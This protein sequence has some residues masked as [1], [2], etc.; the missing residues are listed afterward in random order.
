MWFIHRLSCYDVL[1]S[2]WILT[3]SSCLLH[4][5]I[6]R[7]DL[8]ANHFHVTHFICFYHFASQWWYIEVWANALYSS[9]AAWIRGISSRRSTSTTS[10]RTSW[11][12]SRDSS[13]EATTTI[14]T[15]P[16][17]LRTPAICDETVSPRGSTEKWRPADCFYQYVTV[18]SCCCKIWNKPN[19]CKICKKHSS[20]F[21]N[22]FVLF[23]WWFMKF[24]DRFVLM[25]H[26]ISAALACTLP[27][28]LCYYLVCHNIQRMIFTLK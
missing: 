25:V 17:S 3:F 16:W 8:S 19:L 24:R 14:N 23:P 2:W 12:G 27:D 11:K 28:L 6:K 13:K 18:W 22:N 1:F 10:W 21:I 4:H 20:S 7:E 26:E 15:W 9:T 5:K